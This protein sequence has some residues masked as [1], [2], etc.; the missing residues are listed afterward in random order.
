LKDS[1]KFERASDGY[2]DNNLGLL[3]DKK[4]KTRKL[5]RDE[6]YQRLL[7]SP[8]EFLFRKGKVNQSS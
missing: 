6:G 3:R 5:N 1:S 2:T 4:L 7:I 8:D